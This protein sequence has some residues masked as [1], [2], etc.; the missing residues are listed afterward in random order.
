MRVLCRI[1][2]DC[3]FWKIFL[4][5]IEF[6]AGIWL[7]VLSKHV[8]TLSLVCA[9]SGNVHLVVNLT[10]QEL[11]YQMVQKA[12]P[13]RHPA[14]EKPQG[15]WEKSCSPST[16]RA[17]HTRIGRRAPS[18][19]KVSL[20]AY[21]QG[22]CSCQLAKQGGFTRNS[23]IIRGQ[24]KRR[25][26]AEARNPQPAQ[27]DFSS[28]I[29]NSSYRCVFMVGLFSSVVPQSPFARSSSHFFNFQIL[30][31][32]SSLSLRCSSLPPPSQYKEES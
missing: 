4:L 3:W 23:S 5:G 9:A 19:S 30:S 15:P 1:Y 10:E 20:E 26:A 29:V 27:W 14:P 24:D 13:C 2:L 8:A 21:W 31:F 28:F 16:R 12:G 18:F 25:S 7:M 32:M 22:L 11:W 17:S 6:S